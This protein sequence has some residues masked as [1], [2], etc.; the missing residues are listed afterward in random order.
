MVSPPKDADV[1]RA[2]TPQEGEGGGESE[3]ESFG[4]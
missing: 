2:H 4:I 3:S 1:I